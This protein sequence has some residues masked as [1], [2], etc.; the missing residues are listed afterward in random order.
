MLDEGIIQDKPEAGE[1][2]A[3]A[4]T[5]LLIDKPEDDFVAQVR[6][7]L[8][9][10]H[11]AKREK[12]DR[13]KRDRR[14]HDGEQWDESDVKAA[15]DVKRPA[16]TLNLMLSL[17][18]AIEGE[19]RSNRKAIKFY[20]NE[21]QDENCATGLNRIMKWIEKSC[22]GEFA[23]STAFRNA[24][25]A[26]ED[27]LG[28]EV[29]YYED[30]EGKICLVQVDDEEIFD[31]PLDVSETANK[32]RYLIRCKMWAE[33]E[34]EAKWPESLA[35]LHQR[36]FGTDSGMEGDRSGYRDIY[37]APDDTGSL[38]LYD[39]KQKR[40]AV[41]EC[42]WHQI[43]PGHIVANPQT[44]LLEEYDAKEFEALVAQ[45]EQEQMAAMQ[46]RV[47]HALAP[48]PM[49]PTPM[50]PMAAPKP[51]APEI[52]PAIEAIERPIRRFFQAF[53]CGD[54]LLERKASPIEGLKRFPYVPIRAYLKK[55]SKEYF[56]FIRPAIDP[57]L[58]YNVEQS[59][60]TQLEQLMPKSSWMAP[61]GAFHNKQDWM[62]KLAQP[63]QLLEYNAARGKPEPIQPPSISRHFAEMAMLRPQQ[64]REISGVP[65]EMSG[66]RNGADTGVVIDK[67]SK[68]GRTALT[69]FF[70]HYRAT[71]IELGRVLLCYIQQFVSVGRKIR[72]IGEEGKA[73]YVE[74]TQDMRSLR[75]DITVDEGEDSVNERFEA[76]FVLQTTLPQLAKAGVPITPEFID[77]LPLPP[78][79]RR[80]WRRQIAWEMTVANRLPPPNWKEGDGIPPPPM[81]PMGA[82]MGAPAQ[83]QPQA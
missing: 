83:P 51:P 73:E 28:V 77:L 5:V 8:K 42:W 67:R 40:W 55:D 66:N 15:R 72:V 14:I 37:L 13:R 50:G 7:W 26:G 17:I 54:K 12:L 32:G 3:E 16:L 33:D 58:Q 43:V 9:E 39:S 56:G 18:Q 22:G 82:P 62:A 49:M 74:M 35:S 48:A 47:D 11:G 27:W 70:D 34:I 21:E 30:A 31:D 65:L 38:K 68:A 6:C 46:A 41:I 53:I 63:G 78:H 44:G 60:L 20:G 61:K 23:L 4:G 19:E 79:L 71:K 25:I 45:R 64:V 75:Y 80:A 10:S 59:V 69:G 52:P 29:D 1:G 76:L 2:E 81:P 24:A 57:Q 36:S